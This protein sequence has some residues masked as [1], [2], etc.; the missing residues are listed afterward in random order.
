MPEAPQIIDIQ[1]LSQDFALGYEAGKAT[2]S[3]PK[4][5]A[6]MCGLSRA[7][8]TL[9]E[10]T[11]WKEGDIVW[12]YTSCGREKMPHPNHPDPEAYVIGDCFLA[13]AKVKRGDGFSEEVHLP[14]TPDCNT[15]EAL[16]EP[17]ATVSLAACLL[18][19][20]VLERKFRGCER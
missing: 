13:T 12:L 3:G 14:S 16:P 18:L 6:E 2:C 11:V 17:S 15:Y 5:E 9:V 1:T 4:V 7:N 20:V 8:L 19:L 10:Q